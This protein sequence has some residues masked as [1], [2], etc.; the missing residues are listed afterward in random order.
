M[1]EPMSEKQCVLPIDR[2]LHLVKQVSEEAWDAH[3]RRPGRPSDP[4]QPPRFGGEAEVVDLAA[5]VRETARLGM[6]EHEGAALAESIRRLGALPREDSLQARLGGL[7]ISSELREEIGD[8]FAEELPPSVAETVRATV[9]AYRSAERRYHR[10][11]PSGRETKLS[12]VLIPSL[13]MPLKRIGTQ[14]AL[15]AA[16]KLYVELC[17]ICDIWVDGYEGT[18]WLRA[19]GLQLEGAAAATQGLAADRRSAKR[20]APRGGDLF[21]APDGSNPANTTTGRVGA[22]EAV[23]EG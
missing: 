18:L 5:A 8:R 17:A 21:E 11:S 13:G 10:E 6:A 23:S 15:H 12:S 9:V 20:G 2:Y 22:S 7:E 4:D 1:G 3:R 16:R 14:V 19:D